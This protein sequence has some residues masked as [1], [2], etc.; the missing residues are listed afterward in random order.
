MAKIFK[1]RIDKTWYYDVEG[2]G[3]KAG[4]G[5]EAGAVKAK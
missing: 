3:G 2:Q 4:I 1:V 5:G